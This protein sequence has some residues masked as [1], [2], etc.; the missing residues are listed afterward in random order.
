MKR[1]VTFG[2]LAVCAMSRVAF[3]QSDCQQR[4][5]AVA[6]TKAALTECLR[7]GK[8]CKAEFAA[9]DAARAA[10]GPCGDAPAEVIEESIP[11]DGSPPKPAPTPAGSP[12]VPVA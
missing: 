9:S 12:W 3:A 6:K 1:A 11:T 4:W 2:V 7:S 5:E 10:A 8:S